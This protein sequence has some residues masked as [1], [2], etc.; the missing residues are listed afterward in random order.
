MPTLTIDRLSTADANIDA[1]PHF[2][3]A[4]EVFTTALSLALDAMPGAV[5]SGT[6]PGSVRDEVSRWIDSGPVSLAVEP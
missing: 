6:V 2:G 1:G 3:F 4:D 5:L